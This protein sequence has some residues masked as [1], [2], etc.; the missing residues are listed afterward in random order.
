MGRWSIRI[1]LGAHYQRSEP[2]DGAAMVYD[3]EESFTWFPLGNITQDW[4]E[5]YLSRKL[6]AR[7]GSD[8]GLA[9]A[10]RAARALVEG[11]R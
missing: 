3:P 9:D 4:F 11:A 5:F 8:D 7:P 6:R 2:I 10:L 1:I